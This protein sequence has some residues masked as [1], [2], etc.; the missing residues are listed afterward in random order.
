ML[1]LVVLT[2]YLKVEPLAHS[3]FQ[4][5]PLYGRG[6]LRADSKDFLHETSKKFPKNP[7][8]YLIFIIKSGII[9]IVEIK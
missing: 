2:L 5:T 9:F 7:D 6:P 3:F 4:F 1:D 8:K